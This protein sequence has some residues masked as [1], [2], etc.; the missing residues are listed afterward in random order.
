M[1]YRGYTIEVN[2]YGKGE[3]TIYDEATGEDLWFK[4]EDEAKFYVDSVCEES[5]ETAEEVL[6]RMW[7]LVD[8]M[9]ERGWNSDIER[10]LYRISGNWISDHE[11][12]HSIEMCELDD[13]F[14]IGDE[15]F[16]F[17]DR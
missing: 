15:S 10:K 2:V 8:L 5:F 17:E 1:E 12:D 14:M 6:N 16:I 9:Y 3:Y 4:S 11:Y 7:E 13:G